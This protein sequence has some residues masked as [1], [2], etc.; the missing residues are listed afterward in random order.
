MLLLL[1]VGLTLWIIYG[2]MR[3][4]LVIISANVASL[5][6]LLGIIYFKLRERRVIARAR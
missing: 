3:S 1:V 4:D 6:L 2:L 5:T